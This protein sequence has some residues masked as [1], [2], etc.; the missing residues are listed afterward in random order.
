MSLVGFAM[1]AVGFLSLIF[2]LVNV[3]FTFLAFLDKIEGPLG[4]VVKIVLMFGGMIILYLSK[5]DN[6][7]Y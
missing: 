4:L 3:S 5:T 1:F 7:P 6:D 2:M